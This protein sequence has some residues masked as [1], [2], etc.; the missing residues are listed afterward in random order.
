M[1]PDHESAVH[2]KV[3]PG[4]RTY[5]HGRR[6]AVRAMV[7][8]ASL[9]ALLPNAGQAHDFHSTPSGVNGAEI[10]ITPD[11]YNEPYHPYGRT[12]TVQ[13]RDFLPL[14]QA[15]IFQC[16]VTRQTPIQRECQ[17]L[18][19]G[20]TDPEGNFTAEVYMR[21]SFSSE[22]HPPTPNAGLEQGGAHCYGRDYIDPGGDPSFQCSVV[23]RTLRK[24]SVAA[25]TKMA[26]HY[27]CFEGMWQGTGTLDTKCEIDPTHPTTTTTS[28]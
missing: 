26:E 20:Q 11:G 13:G 9:A 25:V 2:T 5:A 12:Y 23:A 22:L 8:A 3:M 1:K 10:K 24:D 14:D 28:P 21:R 4:L 19:V 16:P 15:Q 27:I 18:G 7:L 17:L 6:G